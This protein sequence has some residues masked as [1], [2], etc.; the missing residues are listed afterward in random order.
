ML[1][2]H[3]FY[4]GEIVREVFNA[5][6]MF[7][8]SKDMATILSMVALISVPLTV[9]QFIGTHSPKAI[10]TWCAV[11]VLVPTLLIKSTEDIQIIDASNPLHV[12]TVGN[13]P[14]ILAFPAHFA[15][16]YMFG[17]IDSIN[18][19]FHT[20]ED[21][22]Y[23][24]TGML[25]GATLV[26]KNLTAKIHNPQ[27][28]HLWQQYLTNCI[29][30]DVAINN[31]YTY[32]ELFSSPDML[33][34]LKN[35]SPSPL[36]RIL[37]PEHASHYS[38]ESGRFPTCKEALPVITS[39]F[40]QEATNQPNYL[41][42]L[43]GADGANTAKQSAL[44]MAAMDNANHA[45]ID[46][47]QNA[48]Q[49]I[50]QA[51]VT[52]STLTGLIDASDAVGADATAIRLMAAQTEIQ[53]NAFMASTGLWAQKRIPML[54]TV[55]LLLIMCASP[56]VAALAM[57]PNMSLK[58]LSNTLIGYLNI[59]SWPIVFTFIN[60]ISHAFG[61]AMMKS[62]T[63]ADGGVTYYNLAELHK[64][65]LEMSSIAGWLMMLTPI[66]TPFLVKGGASIMGSAAMQFAGMMNSIGGQ[67]SKEI[68]TGNISLG[69]T[70]ENVHSYDN[71]H[72][73]K[74][75]TN[76]LDNH[77]MAS[78]QLD[79]GSMKHLT[80][81]GD[82]VYST[83]GSRSVLGESVQMRQDLT[84]RLTT[85]STQA[86]RTVNTASGDFRQASQDTYQST[87]AYLE[88]TA[89]QQQYGSSAS[90]SEQSTEREALSRMMSSAQ[91]YA[92]QHNV[93]DSEAWNTLMKGSLS[94]GGSV[95]GTGASVSVEGSV[96]QGH[97]Y[98]E[99]ESHTDSNNDQTAFNQALESATTA[100]RQ[101]S[102]GQSHSQSSAE[103]HNVS[104]AFSQLTSSGKTLSSAVS[105]ERAASLALDQSKT[106]GA[107]VNADMTPAFQ[108]W[109]EAKPI[110]YRG[111][112]D[113]QTLLTSNDQQISEMR[114]HMEN[115]FIKEQAEAKI[116][117]QLQ[118][119]TPEQTANL[120]TQTLESVEAQGKEQMKR[121]TDSGPTITGLAHD[122]NHLRTDI[123]ELKQGQPE[124]DTSAA[125]A[126][127]HQTDQRLEQGQHHIHQGETPLKRE[128][129]DNTHRI[130]RGD[131]KDEASD[132]IDDIKDVF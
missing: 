132:L 36:R 61:S 4:A 106:D 20:N 53:S 25:Y 125:R 50:L 98:S 60:F 46:V 7:V 127:T 32:E 104:D 37:D 72:A 97:Q 21:E 75:D 77:S 9:M 108:R 95:F 85:A 49:T 63:N 57:L 123:A 93:S 34:F 76:Y 65:N 73:N 107:S 92:K 22:Q 86:A 100:A 62:I 16:L 68:A 87:Q 124:Y 55:I 23:S 58:V 26:R 41:K 122:A 1:T 2:V 71:T 80:G 120:R 66:I 128:A 70:S 82:T 51:M 54:Q 67:V 52:N 115:E 33:T 19:I 94:A 47:S 14:M 6:A 117:D 130:I 96:S 103:Q 42:R 90:T 28:Q 59:A 24:K 88:A 29:R 18:G 74:H 17:I 105:R 31:K 131:L 43:L 101:H 3:V 5:V 89:S 48:R 11:T 27:L 114:R 119:I 40:K 91:H 35:H 84:N 39:L 102:S 113:A 81:S 109:V 118:A 129:M 44:M 56:I 13:V 78:Q 126:Q 99:G 83:Q 121:V 116:N 111:G 8:N 110:D 112:H 69:N 79:N 45:L 10:I 38:A 30:Q 12:T 64:T 15:T